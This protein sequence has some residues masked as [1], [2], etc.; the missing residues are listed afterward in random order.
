MKRKIAI[1]I[2]SLIILSGCGDTTT[3]TTN[4]YTS[5]G[6]ISVDNSK[7]DNSENAE[8]YVATNADF[9]TNTNVSNDKSTNNTIT[10]TTNNILESSVKDSDEYKQL[11]EENNNLRN[12]IDELESN[13]IDIPTIEYKDLGLSINGE[14]IPINKSK[15]MIIVDGKEYVSKE[16]VDSLIPENQNVTINDD[17]MYVG[18][19]VSDKENLSTQWIVDQSSNLNFQD[20]LK[21]SYGNSHSNALLFDGYDGAIIYNLN[22]NYSLL[23]CQISISENYGINDN[24]TVIIKADDEVVYSIDLTKKSMPIIEENIPINNCML[25]TFEFESSFGRDSCIISDAIVYN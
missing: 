3:N 9:D 13:N 16:V 7:N 25:L 11:E 12:Q 14:D 22:S 19:V 10:S 5:Q 23:K 15:S 20:N 6:A 24:A 1:I 2:F 8:G 4:T 18:K 17:I 21:D